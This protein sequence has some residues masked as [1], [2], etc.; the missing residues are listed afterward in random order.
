MTRVAV[1][2]ARGMLG[3]RVVDALESRDYRVFALGRNLLDITLAPLTPLCELAPDVVVNCAAY[4]DVD[5]AESDKQNAYRVNARGA[6]DVALACDDI[7]ARLLHI[8]TDYV[9]DGSASAPYHELTPPSPLG[10]YGASKALGEWYVRH[11]CRRFAIVRT[12]GLFGRGG[13][14]FVA[15]ILEQARAGKPLTVVDDQTSSPTLSDDLAKTIC[16]LIACEGLGI[17]HATSSDSC[18][19]FELATEALRQTGLDV[20]LTPIKTSE[21]GRPA[22]RPSYSVLANNHLP[23]EGIAPLPS[24][25]DA[26]GR[27]LATLR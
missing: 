25:K 16:E 5:G 12:S 4:T 10:I 22:P 18:S 20:P 19:W 23:L 1:I 11:V 27:Y 26:L 6:R 3:R 2:G 7:G 15:T 9:F 17:F 13:R 14:H 8:S 24:W 21:L